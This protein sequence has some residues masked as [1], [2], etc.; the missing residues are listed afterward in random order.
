MRMRDQCD[1]AVRGNNEKHQHVVKTDNDTFNWI[2]SN[3]EDND[4]DSLA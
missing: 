4:G 2:M 3:E 1:E